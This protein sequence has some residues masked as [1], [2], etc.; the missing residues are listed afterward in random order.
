[1]TNQ[2]LESLTEDQIRAKAH[3]IWLAR[4]ESGEPGDSDTDWQEAVK[5]LLEEFA[6]KTKAKLPKPSKPYLYWIGAAGLVTLAAAAV[7]FLRYPA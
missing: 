2:M 3:K 7:I 4:Q 6:P 5:V 1:M